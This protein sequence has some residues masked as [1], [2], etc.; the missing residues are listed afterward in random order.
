MSFSL[1]DVL[2]LTNDYLG[3]YT[4]GTIETAQKYRA[5]NRSIEYIKRRLGLPSDET[6]QTIQFSADQI[7]YDLNADVDEVFLIKYNNDF[8]NTPTYFWDYMSDTDILKRAGDNLDK[9][10]AITNI[11]GRKQIV[12]IGSNI[13]AG[14]TID[15]MEAVGDW[16]VANDASALVLDT[17][18]RYSGGGSLK[19]TVTYSS[20]AVTFRNTNLN[21]DFQTLFENSGMIKF[22]CRSTSANITNFILRIYTDSSNYKTITVTTDDAGNAFV[23]NSFFKVGFQVDDSV[24]TLGTLDTSTITRIDIE[25]TI[26][27]GFSS[28]SMWIDDVF[29][30]IPDDIDVGYYSSNKGTDSTGATNKTTLDTTTDLV[31]I[32]SMYDDFIDIIARKAALNLYPQL[33]GDKDFYTVFVSE[34]NDTM[35]TLSRTFPRKRLQGQS[36][37][38]IERN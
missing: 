20:G 10:W 25:A 36:T 15:S 14:D 37:H 34:F 16:V 35:R 23:A 3:N 30:T 26:P 1:N 11:N 29:T 7:Y 33:K 12:L 19:A 8:Y 32:G 31:G 4:T 9:R 13:R 6:Y 28:G 17:N 38:K 27:S 2:N 5:I 22:W 18:I 21:L 24:A